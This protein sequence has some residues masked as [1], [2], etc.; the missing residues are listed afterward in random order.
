MELK[1]VGYWS[2]IKIGFV[3]NIVIGFIIGIFYAMMMK[4]ML[5]ASGG[6]AGM[7]GGM[8]MPINE[9]TTFALIFMPFM[10]AF[11]NA[12]FG[13]ILW[14]IIAV[15]YNIM[16]RIAGGL[17]LNLEQAQLQPVAAAVPQPVAPQTAFQPA[18]PTRPPS[19]PPPPPPPPVEP[20]PPNITPPAPDNDKY[21]E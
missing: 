7:L 4:I 13:T 18:A 19:P 21:K 8:D 12:F 17:E 3:I 10:F 20:L 2:V 6:F 9:I 5:S 1:S 14:V 11:G 15:I 16:A